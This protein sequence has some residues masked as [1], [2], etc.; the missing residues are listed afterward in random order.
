LQLSAGSVLGTITAPAQI[1]A[2]GLTIRSNSGTF[3]VDSGASDRVGVYAGSANLSLPGGSITVPAFR[4]AEASNGVLPAS[5]VPLKLTNGGD[6]WDHRFL[7]DAIDLDARLANFRG[8][9][10]AQLGIASGQAFF[11][12]VLPS[13]T[14]VAY[15]APYFALPR[16]DVLIGFVIASAAAAASRANQQE[17]VSQVMQLWQAG[18]TWGMLAK[19][20]HVSS[21]QVF[22]GLVEAIKKV[23][24][25]LASPTPRIAIGPVTTASPPTP[26]LGATPAPTSRAGPSPGSPAPTPS[27]T[28]LVNQLLDPVTQLLNKIISLLLGQPIIQTVRPGR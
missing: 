13:M 21:D 22:A 8:G 11:R 4:Q 3:R 6:V 7:Q 24:I 19:E 25:S 17:T 26:K 27:T 5:P 9:L 14:E 2:P 18:E 12:L 23:G 10:D 20:Y 1:D 15:V 28:P 16:S